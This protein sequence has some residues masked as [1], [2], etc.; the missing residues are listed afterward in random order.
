MNG[1]IR[2]APG[3]EFPRAFPLRDGRTL[4]LRRMAVEDAAD[5]LDLGRQIGSETDFMLID[6][7]GFGDDLQRE[8]EWIERMQNRPR[9]GQFLGVVDGRIVCFFGVEGEGRLGRIG[10]AVLK[11]YWG[12]GVGTAI[13]TALVDF[14]RSVGLAELKMCI[15]DRLM[16]VRQDRHP[17]LR[18]RAPQAHGRPPG[19][20]D[21]AQRSAHGRAPA[22]PPPAP[23]TRAA[24]SWPSARTRKAAW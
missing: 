11:D 22:P 2:P 21:F 16:A 20:P 17:Q 3:V 6:E 10:L 4:Q 5:L 12:L 7:N 18:L 14:A 19:S 13:M 9:T 24:G 15:R 23:S 8:R 1:M